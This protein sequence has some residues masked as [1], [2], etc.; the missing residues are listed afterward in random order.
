MTQVTLTYTGRI[1][2]G[3]ESKGHSG[4]SRK[5]GSHIICAAVS[6]LMHSLILGLEDIAKVSGAKFTVND[7][8]PVISLS[9]PASEGE[10]ISLLTETIGASLRQIALENPGQVK[11][12]QEEIKSS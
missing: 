7:K 6:A 10:R 3:I 4:S 2:T 8:V 11:I 1:L 5:G 9:W 12:R